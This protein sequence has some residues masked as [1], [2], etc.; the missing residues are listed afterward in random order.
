[1]IKAIELRKGKTVLHD[2][3]LCVVHEIQHVA[4]G[5]KRSHMQAKLR[6]IKTGSMMDVRFSVD[7][8]IEVPFVESK[9]YEFL[10]REGTNFVIMDLESF[11]QLTVEEE[12]VGDAAQ[13]L[14]PNEKVTCQLF[15]G[16]IVTF[17][18]PFTVELTIADCPPSIKGATVTNQSKEAVLETGAKVRVPPFIEPGTKIRVDTRTGEYLERVK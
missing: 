5:N 13:W 7:D 17:E 18:M 6:N 1:M 11:D 16:R 9:S 14:T 8:T 10:Y 3:Q 2:G 12:I 4:K 15:D